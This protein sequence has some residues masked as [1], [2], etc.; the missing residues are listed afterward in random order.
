M[1]QAN[2]DSWDDDSVPL[3]SPRYKGITNSR[4]Q[5]TSV[6]EENVGDKTVSTHFKCKH[7][8]KT[9]LLQI[10]ADVKQGSHNFEKTLSFEKV[11]NL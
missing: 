3:S 9:Y 10:S 1:A 6:D 4:T 11:N 5:L 8:F 2:D 7:V